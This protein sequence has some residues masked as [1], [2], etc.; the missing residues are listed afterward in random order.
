MTD[1][2]KES[3]LFKNRLAYD[4]E[5][6]K[7]YLA[8]KEAMGTAAISY[9]NSAFRAL[10]ILN[11]GAIIGILTFLGN[12]VSRQHED[13]RHV[14]GYVLRS[15]SHKI[16]YFIVGLILVVAAIMISYVSQVSFL[17]VRGRKLK[18]FIPLTQV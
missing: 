11:G 13:V 12:L 7:A 8:F 16:S 9:A 15:L 4:L 5:S 14:E 1:G 10:L 17:E 6:H 18:G 2:E 3:E